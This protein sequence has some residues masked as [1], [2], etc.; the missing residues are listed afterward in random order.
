MKDWWLKKI[1]RGKYLDGK[2]RRRREKCTEGVTAER[3][4]G[5]P[6]GI[7]RE[8]GSDVA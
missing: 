1:G 8:G 5:R 3:G 4:R 6:G 2:D 7:L